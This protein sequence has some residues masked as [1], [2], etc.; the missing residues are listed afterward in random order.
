MDTLRVLIS[1]FEAWFKLAYLLG[2]AGLLY[3][4][5]SRHVYDDP[6]ITYRYASNLEAGLGFVYNPGQRI[7]STTTPL[8]ALILALLRNFWSDLHSLAIFIGTLSIAM[9]G[10]LFCELGR[11][12]KTPLVGW[13]GLLL[14]PTFPL[15]LSTLGSETPLFLAFCLG[16]FLFYANQ[17]LGWA[18]LLLSFAILT[19][20]DGI[21]VAALLGVHYLWVNRTEFNQLDFWKKQP[22]GWIVVALLI[23]LAWHSFAWLYFSAP[24]PVTLAAKQAQGRMAI[25]QHFAPGILRVVGWYAKSWQYW[26]E[27][28]LLVIGVFFAF[29][30]KRPWLLLLGWAGLYFLAYSLLGVTSYFWYYAPLVPGWVV[31]VGLGLAFLNGV[32]LPGRL[33]NSLFGT[34]IRP[35]LVGIL[36]VALFFAHAGNLQKMSQR[37]DPRYAIYRAAGEWLAENTPP[38]AR[39]GALEVGI[40]GYYAQRPM[41]DFAGLIQPQVA[42]RMQTDT[43]YN[44]TAIWAVQKYR[45]QYLAL[46][47]GSLP[48]LEAEIVASHCQPVERFAGSKFGFP[49]D[50]QIYACQYD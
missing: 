25:S 39:V 42:E 17:R 45:P 32:P 22:W 35:C 44:D 34:R 24:L 10:L 47:A 30:K 48:R 8:F 19:R 36:L 2:V 7:L 15:L 11:T 23:L 37:T 14:Y 29:Y 9:G 4:A 49:T 43:T 12:W 31:A 50:L 1:R 38:D 21:L 3:W 6:F 5:F 33:R 27:F 46:L 18:I 16:A 40:I 41:V 28:G 13:S 26:V 20:S